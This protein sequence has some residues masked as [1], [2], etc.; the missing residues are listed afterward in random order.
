MGV[1]RV[2]GEL[3]KPQFEAYKVIWLI[4]NPGWDRS[5][6]V[7]L[8]AGFYL[9]DRTRA[10]ISEVLLGGFRKV[11]GQTLLTA[12]MLNKAASL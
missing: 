3:C 6:L 11:T 9:Q 2:A 7:F 1:Y 4:A 12:Y 8:K 10:F 5:W